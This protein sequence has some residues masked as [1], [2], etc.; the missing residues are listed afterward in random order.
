MTLHELETWLALEV[1]GSYHALL[2]ALI[3][4]QCPL[5]QA[6]APTVGI[7]R[8]VEDP[9]TRAL[10]VFMANDSSGQERVREALT[11]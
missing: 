1:I 8:I 9:V 11:A 7:G 4:R 3:I 5:L 10:E 6:S 2:T